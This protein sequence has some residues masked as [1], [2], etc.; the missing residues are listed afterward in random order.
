MALLMLLLLCGAEAKKKRRRG[1]TAPPLPAE[2]EEGCPFWRSDAAPKELSEFAHELERDGRK[3]EALPCYVRAIRAAPKEPVGWLDLAV[4]KQHDEPERAIELY[5]HGVRLSPSDGSLYNNLG[6]LLRT[7]GRGEE[8][9]ACF[10]H[11]ARIEP[12]GADAFF[13]LGGTHDQLDRHAE[14]LHAYRRALEN[15]NKNEARILNNMGLILGKMKSWAE[16]VRTLRE[17]EEADPTFPDTQINLLHIYT[18]HGALDEAKVHLDKAMALVPA[19]EGLRGHAQAWEDAM[20]K[21]EKAQW[22]EK[23]RRD[24]ELR[25]G[26]MTREQRVQRFQEVI[27]RCGMD[28]ECMRKLLGQDDESGDDLVRF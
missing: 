28:K 26:P 8:A 3:A 4:A 7:N 19:D 13:H 21:R 18:A 27:G 1:Q 15:E 5:S 16:A 25:E 9:T 23:R 12:T 10:E 24:L 20:R 22:E 17:A 2:L 11:A 14:A 6:V